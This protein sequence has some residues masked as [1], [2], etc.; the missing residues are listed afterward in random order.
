MRKFVV[1]G[2]AGFVGARIC[3]KLLQS[4]H[5]VTGFDALNS[6]YDPAI[7]RRRISQLCTYDAFAFSSVDIRSEEFLSSLEPETT[8]YHQAGQPGVRSSWS[9][10]FEDYVANNIIGTQMLLERL[11]GLAGVKLVYASSSSVYGNQAHFPC[12]ET[13]VPHPY[14]P[15]GVT[16]L[17]A[18]HLVSLYAENFG[19][20]TVSLRYF[21]VY[22][23]GQRPDMAFTRFI[24]AILSGGSIEIYGDGEQRRDFTYVDDIVEANLAAAERDTEP[25]VIYNVCGGSIVSVNETV[26][27]LA[28]ISGKPVNIK[29]IGTSFGDVR[30]TGGDNTR[31]RSDLSWSP[32]VRIADGLRMQYERQVEDFRAFNGG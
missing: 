17:G 15:Y 19:V 28:A 10:G 27:L 26:E 29:H 7:K 3:Q 21:T 4:G 24:N 12:D 30:E 25:G 1:T 8:I 13:A 31:I 2:A 14:S 18:E 5:K 23:P 9:S 11:R 22:G 32:S 20:D 6:Y 16:K